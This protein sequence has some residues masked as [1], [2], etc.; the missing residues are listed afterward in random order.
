MYHYNT[1]YTLMCEVKHLIFDTLLD[2]VGHGDCQ[3]TSIKRLPNCYRITLDFLPFGLMQEFIRALEITG[4]N[5]LSVKAA[6]LMCHR[7]LIDN[8]IKPFLNF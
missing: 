2:Y 3:I 5:L 8:D 4:S 1:N 7:W 6:S